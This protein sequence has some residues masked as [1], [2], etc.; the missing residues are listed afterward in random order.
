M[1]TVYSRRD[2][3]KTGLASIGGLAGG[4]AL[5][6]LLGGIQPETALAQGGYNVDWTCIETWASQMQSANAW[7]AVNDYFKGFNATYA[8]LAN[9][10]STEGYNP[11]PA[12]IE[13]FCGYPNNTQQYCLMQAY[14]V[15][16]D[17]YWS[18]SAY[19]FWNIN[20]KM[21]STDWGMPG[22]FTRNCPP[23]TSVITFDPNPDLNNAAG[24]G[25]LMLNNW[26]VGAPN[27]YGAEY[28]PIWCD[29]SAQEQVGGP[30]WWTADA[31]FSFE[32][33][34][35]FGT[36]NT[37]GPDVSGWLK[38]DI[39]P[40][41]VIANGDLQSWYKNK[42]YPSG[43][44]ADVKALML[45]LFAIGAVMV[46]LYRYGLAKLTPAFGAAFA[47][48]FVE[49]MGVYAPFVLITVIILAGIY[50]VHCGW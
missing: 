17:W 1:R 30:N 10:I 40:V 39:I 28:Q 49:A 8:S 34:I 13:T 14:N 9:R 27:R 22:H 38:N 41:A 35:N 3:L 11:V 7:T 21:N 15:L 25:A 19:C 29:P 48:A 5:G 20:Q 24:I 45:R 44:C 42:T 2:A 6:R 23:K 12:D 37:S 50:F 26:G 36:T 18:P 43:F 32:G 46:Y 16:T 31:D 4:T 33:D 47:E